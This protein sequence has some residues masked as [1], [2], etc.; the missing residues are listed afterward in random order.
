MATRH[1]R[2]TVLVPRTLPPTP[3]SPR[4]MPAHPF[5]AYLP[6]FS[7]MAPGGWW[8]ASSRATSCASPTTRQTPWRA[9]RCGGR[10]GHARP[11]P[12]LPPDRPPVWRPVPFPSLH[13]HVMGVAGRRPP[14]VWRPSSP[15]SPLP[16][17]PSAVTQVMVVDGEHRI[18]IFA[19]RAAAPGTEITYNYQWGAGGRGGGEGEGGEGTPTP[20]QRSALR[21]PVPLW[22]PACEPAP[23]A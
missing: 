2:A 21:T 13:V 9:R 12:P 22:T 7:C 16:R 11:S 18:G 10:A 1:E 19:A 14:S 8:T 23:C 17:P 4:N 5:P 20:S 6:V 3:P 15:P